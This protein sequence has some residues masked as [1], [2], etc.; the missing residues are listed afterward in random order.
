MGAL[1]RR[2]GSAPTWRPT[3]PGATVRPRLSSGASP[4]ATKT[5]R[6][7]GG[8]FSAAPGPGTPRGS[9]TVE[10]TSS[11]PA[12]SCTG[13][14]PPI[15]VRTR[16]TFFD[17]GAHADMV[18][19][20]RR[21]SFA[22]GQTL[23][24][25][26]A[27]DADLRAR[28]SRSGPTT[29]RSTRTTPTPWSPREWA[30]ASSPGAPGAASQPVGRDQRLLDQRRR[31]DPPRRR[32][33]PG[34]PAVIVRLRRVL[35]LQQHRHHARPAGAVGWLAPVTET[36]YLC[37]YDA[38][39]WPLAVAQRRRAAGRM[40]AGRPR[41]STRLPP[42]VS[43]GAGDPAA[44]ATAFTAT[45]GSLGELDRHLHLPVVALHRATPAKTIG[46]ATG[47]TYT[48]TGAD[49]GRS[50]QVT[51]TATA[52]GGETDS[53]S[54]NNAGTISGTVYEGEARPR[55]RGSPTPASRPAGSAAARAARPPP[56]SRANTCSRCRSPANYEVSAFPGPGSNALPQ[57]P[58]RRDHRQRRSGH[59]AARTSSSAS[60][61]RRRR[62]SASAARA[63]AAT[64]ARGGV[65]VVH[66]QE[67]FVIEYKAPKGSEV[68]VEVEFP[69]QPPERSRRR[70]PPRTGAERTGRRDLQVPGPPLYPNHG[71][72]EVT[73]K[74]KPKPPTGPEETTFPI[75]IDPSGLVR[76]TTGACSPGATVTLYRSDSKVGPFDIVSGRLRG[77][78]ADEPR[79]TR[80]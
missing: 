11:A 67:P 9:R 45:A 57:A 64:A 17:G 13:D 34:R 29:R 5:A 68:E 31:P 16:Y 52:P 7:R 26:R 77:D 48:A 1:R 18:R 56:T 51:V 30:N 32:R 78:V 80:T 69:G 73:I 15:P 71:P 76:T 23:G 36:E 59:A 55:Q 79:R 37:F 27:G 24:Q 46:G 43:A 49:V 28:A 42:T 12:A 39:S 19:I 62:G 41:R 74:I 63:T 58:P 66:W 61:G 70:R 50:L 8:W 25:P 21:W 3:T 40:R 33:A 4:T 6:G 2:Q 75:Y 14:T 38:T 47:T 60:P 35:G 65:P 72:A 53:A 44:R 54:S 10:L 22:S 20:E